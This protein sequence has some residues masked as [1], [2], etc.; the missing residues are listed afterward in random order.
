MKDVFVDNDLSAHFAAP[1]LS[2]YQQFIEWLRDEGALVVSDKLLR[3]YQRCCGGCTIP[4]ALPSLVA[5]LLRDERLHK[6]NKEQ[7]DAVNFSA[8]FWRRVESNHKDH[9][10]IKTVF[11]SF[12]KLAISN[13]AKLRK[14]V[15]RIPGVS[16]RVGKSPSSIPYRLA[17]AT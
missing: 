17:A 8:A 13:D 10:H 11:L 4:T 6:V 2:E 1:I 7:L 9:V 16:T 12:R 15:C 5:W 14:D 3:E